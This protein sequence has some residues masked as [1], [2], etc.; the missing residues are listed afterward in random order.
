[1][2][3]AKTKLPNK[4]STFHIKPNSL[5][6]DEAINHIPSPA[7][8]GAKEETAKFAITQQQQSDDLNNLIGVRSQHYQLESLW[9]LHTP[10]TSLLF[11]NL[12]EYLGTTIQQCQGHHGSALSTRRT[13]SLLAIEY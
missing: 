13:H 10:A 7:Q 4:N 5:T 8:K 9:T 3:A 1:L 11:K 2:L 12:I 6:M